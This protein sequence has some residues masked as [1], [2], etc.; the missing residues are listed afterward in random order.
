MT[1]DE[2]ERK[3]AEAWASM[4]DV[5]EAAFLTRIDELAAATPLSDGSGLFER[6]SALDSTGHAD[7]AVPLYRDALAHGLEGE[8]RRRAAIQ[9]ASSL[10]NLGEIDEAIRLLVDERGAESDEL[11]DA[12]VAFLALALADVGQEREGLSLALEVLAAHL[13]RYQRSLANYAR[14]LGESTR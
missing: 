12:V 11:D 6:A 3:I 1:N 4:G 14:I 13:P 10:R 8:R 9:M 2:W 7:L 5:D